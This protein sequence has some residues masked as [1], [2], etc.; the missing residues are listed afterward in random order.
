MFKAIIGP[1]THF[2]LVGASN[3]QTATSHSTP[4]AEIVAADFALRSHGIGSLDVWDILLA[5]KAILRFEEDN[6]A[7][8]KII[9]KCKS[10][11]LGH[12]KRTHGVNLS[13][14]H[15][16][17][18]SD[19]CILKCCVTDY[20]SA[21]I[22]TKA[23]ENREKF[24]HACALICH[25]FPKL[26]GTSV[27]INHVPKPLKTLQQAE[28]AELAYEDALTG[29]RIS[30]LKS[31][32]AAGGRK[33]GR[34]GGKTSPPVLAKA[35]MACMAVPHQYAT[36]VVPAKLDQRKK[37]ETSGFVGQRFLKMFTSNF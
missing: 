31:E 33:V 30:Q 28:E 22:F 34:S 2:P 15:D 9:V 17:R 10:A 24:G 3:K 21:D 27:L 6:E 35:T 13:A 37:G 18:M 36:P 5:R 29:G 16:W 12:M 7:A 32:L 8:V 23:F 4:E 20:Q 25:Y 11:V 1:N 14:L 19:C 26:N